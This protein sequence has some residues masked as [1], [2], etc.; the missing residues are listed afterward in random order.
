MLLAYLTLLSGLFISVVA[1]YYS[2]SGLTSIFAA[3]VIPIVIMGT[4]LEVGKLVASV[5]LKQNW[6]IAPRLLKAYLLIAVTI[7]M[8]I[9]SMGIFGYLSKAH[10]DQSVVSG[11]SQD[12]V[13]II[14]EKIRTQKDN[15]EAAR[16]A[17]TQMDAAV[18]QTMSRSSDEKGADKAATIR[19]GQ[20]KERGNLQNDIAKAQKEIASLNEQRAPMA[21]ELR[22]I[23]AE[24]G[25]IKYVAALMYGDNPD[26]NILDKAV[27][28]VIILIVVVFDPLAVILL[29]A[30]QYTFEYEKKKRKGELPEIEDEQP[31]FKTPAFVSNISSFIKKK[32]TKDSGPNFEGVRMPDGNWVQTGPSFSESDEW[33]DKAKRTAKS[34][35]DGTY[36][37]PNYEPDDG[38]L[39]DEQIDLI[40]KMAKDELPTGEL[41]S[42]ESLFKDDEEEFPFRGRGLSPSMP[43][44]ASYAQPKI[45]SET[46]EEVPLNEM[47]PLEQWNQMIAEADA[48]AKSVSKEQIPFAG[49]IYKFRADPETG[50]AIVDETLE[51]KDLTEEQFKLI[52]EKI[53]RGEH[54]DFET[55]MTIIHT[56]DS[57]IVEDAAGSTEI[58]ATPTDDVIEVIN[59]EYVRVNGQ[60]RHHKAHDISSTSAQHAVEN[61]NNTYVQNEEQQESGVWSQIVN[62]NITEEE[63]LKAVQEKQNKI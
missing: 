56:P 13:A 27:R 35:D 57:M 9:T 10:M 31:I 58:S 30:S 6:R 12:K 33:F 5:W 39:T 1:I 16:K 63:Y 22:K 11:D 53:E 23:E 54:I 26:Q 37:A 38:A 49:K 62:K 21:K 48:A 29:L 59:D 47:V 55:E 4:S 20:A 51:V 41:V 46:E 45:E 15:I 28:W 42:K 18:D 50:K 36:Q 25:P 32:I 19:R 14:D 61:S 40:R 3:A 17:L 24:V 2:V 7:L 43:M 34:I 60:V 52:T 8:L 44:G